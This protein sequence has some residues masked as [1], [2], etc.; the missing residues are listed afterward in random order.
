MEVS[1]ACSTERPGTIK[2]ALAA[3][4]NRRW[5]RAG[6]AVTGFTGTTALA[7]P[8][9]AQSSPDQITSVNVPQSVSEHG[10]V[11]GD[12]MTISIYFNVPTPA[13]TTVDLKNFKPAVASVPPKIVVPAGNTTASF[14]VTTSPVSTPTTD[15]IVAN[16]TK[17]STFDTGVHRGTLS[18]N[19]GHFA[20]RGNKAPRLLTGDRALRYV[21]PRSERRRR[22]EGPPFRGWAVSY[23]SRLSS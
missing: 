21:E 23:F 3:W 4:A 17:S 9:T 5:L 8:A 16:D 20:N 19:T 15:S 2:T 18:L 13:A 12:S 1:H 14:T 6:R 22:R 11:G 7:A 10:I